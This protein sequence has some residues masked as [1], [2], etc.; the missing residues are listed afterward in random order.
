MRPKE[1]AWLQS[2]CDLSRRLHDLKIG[3]CCRGLNGTL[4]SSREFHSLESKL[5]PHFTMYQFKS[6]DIDA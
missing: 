1:C 5:L 4:V 3:M 6:K 2:A